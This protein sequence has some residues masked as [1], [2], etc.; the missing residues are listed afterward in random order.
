ML[1]SKGVKVRFDSLPEQSRTQELVTS[2]LNEVFS[3][4]GLFSEDQQ[5]EAAEAAA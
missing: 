1:L 2:S 5:E 3:E 4:L